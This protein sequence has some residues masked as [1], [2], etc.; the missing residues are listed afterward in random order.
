M[1]AQVLYDLG[2]SI[3][4]PVPTKGVKH[5]DWKKH[6]DSGDITAQ[7]AGKSYRIE[8][9]GLSVDFSSALNWPFGSE[10][11]VCAKHSFDR[12]KPKPSA[13]FIFNK[14]LTYYARVNL[15]SREMWSEIEK[16]D[17]RYDGVKQK[18]YTCPITLVVWQQT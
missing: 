12:A 6:A 10:F 1:A 18:F 13:Y 7:K 16:T 9:K 15:S 3:T 14:G 11:I 2:F 17:S 8:V 5:E 4:I